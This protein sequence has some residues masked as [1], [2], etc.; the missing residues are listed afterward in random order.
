MVNVVFSQQVINIGENKKIVTV[1]ESNAKLIIGFQDLQLHEKGKP[2]FF[3]A[4]GETK[5]GPFDNIRKKNI[6]STK[7][8]VE[9]S[10]DTSYVVVTEKGKEYVL[11][12]KFKFGPYKSPE[13]LKITQNRATIADFSEKGMHYEIFS[14][15]GDTPKSITKSIK[16]KDNVTGI[17]VS[18]NMDVLMSFDN[19]SGD[20]SHYFIYQGKKTEG[21]YHAV[22]F[23]GWMKTENDG[24]TPVFSC[25]TPLDNE[26][27]DVTDDL[28]VGNRLIGNLVIFYDF[29]FNSTNTDFVVKGYTA[30]KD[31]ARVYSAN[32]V[33]G[34]YESVDELMYDSLDRIQFEFE[35]N[36]S[37]FLYD[38]GVSKPISKKEEYDWKN[39]SPNGVDYVKCMTVEDTSYYYFNDQLI[40]TGKMWNFKFV[41]WTQKHGPVLFE[42][43]MKPADPNPDPEGEPW[44][45]E[46]PAGFRLII[47]GKSTKIFESIL[48]FKESATGEIAYIAFEDGGFYVFRG[49]TKYGPY[50]MFYT[51][52]KE[53]ENFLKWDGDDLIYSA[54]FEGKS[55][56]FKNGESKAYFP[57]IISFYWNQ[58][59][60]SSAIVQIKDMKCF[61]ESDLYSV[62]LDR[63]PI[64]EQ[65]EEQFQAEFEA[66]REELLTLNDCSSIHFNGKEFGGL[67]FVHDLK[68]SQ[69]GS[70]ISFMNM[71]NLNVIY[72]NELLNGTIL[73]NRIVYYMNG[74]VVVSGLD[75]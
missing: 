25:V 73:N 41:T 4:S 14:L 17:Y 75:Q 28:Y 53:R 10:M 38:N 33:L 18:D 26:E 32:S 65:L 61:L 13:L 3:I 60:S 57:S 59:L 67:T 45:G 51:I 29:S 52:G 20:A 54:I 47:D 15:E 24:L 43:I 44:Y 71:D 74:N 39:V 34:P 56:V 5:L 69:D 63:D 31:G 46:V 64:V 58:K 12:G 30:A 9:L 35:Q 27:Y 11:Y 1:L 42:N 22:H 36:G 62:S 72:K 6:Q 7:R 68:F 23:E 49:D 19:N 70:A 16:Y 8:L 66:R 50:A 55:Q 2:S 21:F 37:Q 48:D 40:T